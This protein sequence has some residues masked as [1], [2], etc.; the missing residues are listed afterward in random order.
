MSLISIVILEDGSMWEVSPIEI[1]YS[2][3]WLPVSNIIVVDD[4]G[5][6]P[7]K[8]INT[9]KRQKVSAKYLGIKK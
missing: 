6:Y 2:A 1:I 4:F 9:N 8:L 5:L 7:Y 3:I